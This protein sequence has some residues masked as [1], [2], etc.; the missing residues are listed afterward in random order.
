MDRMLVQS[1]NVAEVGYD[2]DTMTLEVLFKNG[3]LYQYFDVPQQVYEELLHAESV[4]RFLS[5]QIKNVY[6][7]ARL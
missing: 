1:S 5:A 6:R 3:S 2:A 7:Y 4:G